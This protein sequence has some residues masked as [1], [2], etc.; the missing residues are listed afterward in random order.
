[1][2]YTIPK[3]PIPKPKPKIQPAPQPINYVDYIA[4]NIEK[5]IKYTEYLSEKLNNSVNRG[6]KIKNISTYDL[7]PD[8]SFNVGLDVVPIETVQRVDVHN[9][10]I[11][12][13]CKKNKTSS[14]FWNYKL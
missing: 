3:P 7:V 6:M 8:P 4:D 14:D 1:M 10:N 11:G 5:N 13:W 12:W 9:G 2:G